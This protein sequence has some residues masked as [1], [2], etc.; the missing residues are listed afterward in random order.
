ME[1]IKDIRPKGE[2][3]S[4]VRRPVKE[5][6]KDIDALAEGIVVHPKPR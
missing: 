3:L 1:D 5:I 6:M 4:K 2:P